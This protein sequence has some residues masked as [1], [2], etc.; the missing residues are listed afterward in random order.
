MMAFLLYPGS[1]LYLSV[2]S[3]TILQSDRIPVMNP[4]AAGERLPHA[5]VAMRG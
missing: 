5:V 3:P 2:V 1:N 4:R